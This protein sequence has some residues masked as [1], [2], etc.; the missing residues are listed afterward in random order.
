MRP[1]K[2]FETAE[3]T[4]AALNQ[5][6]AEVRQIRDKLGLHDV[7][8]VV[9]SEMKNGDEVAVGFSCQEMGEF[10]AMES[11]AAWAFGKL[12]SEKKEL[13]AKFLSG[14]V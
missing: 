12:Q 13:L 4:N 8:V 6:Y 7:L 9:R 2:P 14:K 1:N 5:F 11:L 10:M 3:A